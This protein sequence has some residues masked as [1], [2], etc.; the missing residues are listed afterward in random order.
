MIFFF[1]FCPPLNECVRIGS[2]KRVTASREQSML[3]AWPPKCVIVFGAL[4]DEQVFKIMV[5]ADSCLV[6]LSL[7]LY[8]PVFQTLKLC[9]LFV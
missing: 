6:V 1:F 8:V 9:M 5:F 3:V 4:L 7:Q 2:E